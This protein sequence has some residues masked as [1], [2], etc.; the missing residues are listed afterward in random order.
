MAAGGTN[1]TITSIA[2]TGGG[3]TVTVSYPP[4][5]TTTPITPAHVEVYENVVD[6]FLRRFDTADAGSHLVNVTVDGTG[7]VNGVASHK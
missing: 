4:D 2:T 7:A 6:P 1:G 3:S 5:T